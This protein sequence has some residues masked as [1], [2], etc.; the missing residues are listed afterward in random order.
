MHRR[1]RVS[2][3][4]A[5]VTVAVRETPAGVAPSPSALAPSALIVALNGNDANPGT[6]AQ[7]LATKSA[8]WS[9]RRPGPSALQPHGGRVGPAARCPESVHDWNRAASA[10]AASREILN[11][12]IPEH[13]SEKKR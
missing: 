9:S 13:R 8:P 10:S 11:A 6:V 7:P 3:G 5:V 4:A 12:H 1:G 2:C